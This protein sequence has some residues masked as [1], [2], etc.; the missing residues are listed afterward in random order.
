MHTELRTICEILRKPACLVR[1]FFYG[2]KLQVV[3]EFI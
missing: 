3:L 1:L 2:K